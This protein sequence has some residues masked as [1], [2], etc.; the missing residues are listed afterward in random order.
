M[1]LGQRCPGLAQTFFVLATD[2]A[3]GS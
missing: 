2:D 3:E 1:K